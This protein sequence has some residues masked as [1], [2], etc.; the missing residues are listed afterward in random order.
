MRGDFHLADISANNLTKIFVSIISR[1]DSAVE[2]FF[3]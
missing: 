2:Q 3:I 1:V